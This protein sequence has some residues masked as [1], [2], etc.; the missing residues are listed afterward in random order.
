MI[1][2]GDTSY[3]LAMKI[4]HLENALNTANS[5]LNKHGMLGVLPNHSVS[6]RKGRTFH[7]KVREVLKKHI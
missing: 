5:V 6:F 2:R 7:K 3:A 1:D 4:V